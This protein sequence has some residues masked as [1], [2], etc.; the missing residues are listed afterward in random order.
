MCTSFLF[1][2]YYFGLL[3]TQWSTKLRDKINALCPFKQV[4]HKYLQRI[5]VVYS[6]S[7]KPTHQAWP[8]LDHLKNR[9]FIQC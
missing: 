8:R 4:S 6:L 2:V 9:L 7:A 1:I 3:K 5:L